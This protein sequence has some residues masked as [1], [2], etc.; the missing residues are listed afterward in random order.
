MHL[1][2]FIKQF[3]DILGIFL[4]LIRSDPILLLQSPSILLALLEMLLLLTDTRTT[5]QADSQPLH[6]ISS[7]NTE[8]ESRDFISPV[9]NNKPDAARLQNQ[10]SLPPS[11]TQAE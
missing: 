2:T 9:I 1:I 10:P 11:T 4:A 3:A 7:I 5:D 8:E 6:T